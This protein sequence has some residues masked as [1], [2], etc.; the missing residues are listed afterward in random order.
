MGQAA[1]DEEPGIGTF[2][3]D[4]EVVA[5]RDA[6]PARGALCEVRHQVAL[7]VGHRDLDH[8]V[9]KCRSKGE[10]GLQV[11]GHRVRLRVGL[12]EAHHLIDSEKRALHLLLEGHGEVVDLRAYPIEDRLLAFLDEEGEAAPENRERGDAQGDQHGLGTAVRWYGVGRH[13][14]RRAAAGH[15]VA[16]FP[17]GA[18]RNQ[19]PE[20]DGR[21]DGGRHRMVW[22]A[23]REGGGERAGARTGSKPRKDV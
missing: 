15:H 22:S 14:V 18:P 13:R 11:E 8:D 4:P 6:R 3:L 7:R 5:V 17:G 19:L 2:Q 23:C 1:A 16:R 10:P 20:A 21:C 9:G 12:G